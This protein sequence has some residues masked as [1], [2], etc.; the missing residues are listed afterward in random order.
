[1]LCRIKIGLELEGDAE[2]LAS[3]LQDTEQLLAG[4]AGEPVAT[5]RDDTI[6]DLDVD[7]VSL[8]FVD[9]RE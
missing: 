7:V 5:G 3:G 8:R 1:V 6:A 9:D 2:L 4:D